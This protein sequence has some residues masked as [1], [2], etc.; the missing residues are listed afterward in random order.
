MDLEKVIHAKLEKNALKYP[1]HL[2]KGNS[3]KY[4]QPKFSLMVI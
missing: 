4:D 1:V 3:R 2:S